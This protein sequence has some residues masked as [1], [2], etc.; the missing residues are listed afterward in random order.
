M[1]LRQSSIWSTRSVTLSS[2][3]ASLQTLLS[4]LTE[5]YDW[6]DTHW[7]WPLATDPWADEN[8]EY[9]FHIHD[10]HSNYCLLYTSSFFE[11]S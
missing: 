9:F 7:D 11:L 2:G 4:A 3:D 8:L 6:V 1:E 10:Q 5:N